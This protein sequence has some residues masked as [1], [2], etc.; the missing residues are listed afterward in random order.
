MLWS[1]VLLLAFSSNFLYK[2]T[3][4]WQSQPLCETEMC[5]SPTLTLPSYYMLVNQIHLLAQPLLQH[6]HPRDG[7]WPIPLLPCIASSYSNKK[8]NVLSYASIS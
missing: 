2:V 7:T 8:K 4:W 3:L 1:V 5:L 6:L